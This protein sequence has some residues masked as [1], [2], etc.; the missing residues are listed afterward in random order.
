MDASDLALLEL[1]YRAVG[2]PD[3]WTAAIAGMAQ[4]MRAG[5]AHFMAFP[6]ADAP[7][8]MQTVGLG[9]DDIE[10]FGSPRSWALW[11][12]YQYVMPRN[13]PVLQGEIIRD[14][15]FERSDFYNEIVRPS[16]GFYSLTLQQEAAPSIWQ[17][18][19][20]RPRK[21]GEYTDHEATRLSR[22]IPHLAS[23]FTL[24]SR[25]KLA[26][27][28]ALGLSK[29]LDRLDDGVLLVGGSGAVDFA[30]ASALRLL[31]DPSAWLLQ[32][33][34][35]ER[36]GA[37]RRL[38][39]RDVICELRA[40]PSRASRRLY[41][42][43]PTQSGGWLIIDVM[44][45]IGFD[46]TMPGVSAPQLAVFI[47]RTGACADLDRRAVEDIYHLTPRESEIAALLARGRGPLEIS[48]TI[49][50]TEQTVRFYLKQI[51]AKT[52]TGGQ[53]GL[54][55]TLRPYMAPQR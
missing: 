4:I 51:F 3:A 28:R 29:A 40:D 53:T 48:R 8:F 32:A 43:E 54:V 42:E 31:L 27:E 10:R 15:Q 52:G 50:L 11:K 45:L 22:I 35:V 46:L 21:A 39:L 33:R 17:L 7:P 1:L 47:R 38:R 37:D 20:C 34:V 2:D 23:V 9:E 30:N 5:H 19:F 16:G 25:L 6:S 44:S 55:A 14:D 41:G 26:E 49:G 13:R 18:T 36:V 24:H 12:P